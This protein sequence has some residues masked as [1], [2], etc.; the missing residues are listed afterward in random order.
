MGNMTIAGKEYT[1]QEVIA[2]AE[3]APGVLGAIAGFSLLNSVL[4]LF[5]V[6]MMF[7][8]GLGSTFVIDALLYTARQ[9]A[10]GGPMLVLT[11]IGLTI[12]AAIIGLFLLLWWLSRRGSRAA[13]ITAGVLYLLDGL[14]FLLLQ[15]WMG[16]GFHVFFLFLLFGG[17]NFVKHRAEAAA[18]LRAMPEVAE[19]PDAPVVPPPLQAPVTAEPDAVEDEVWARLESL[20][21]SLPAYSKQARDQMNENGE[22]NVYTVLAQLGFSHAGGGDE[23]DTGDMQVVHQH[24]MNCERA[25]YREQIKQYNALA[26]GSLL[27]MHASGRLDDAGYHEAGQLLA[28]FAARKLE[29]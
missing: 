8:I 19:G 17:Y 25:G 15:D 14:I 27:G 11:V 21:A 29:R 5:N 2:Q 12:N 10:E 1:P 16:V 20:W 26:L 18:H 6:D 9:E 24:L 28:E 23:W 7:V 22:E 3:R 13:Y 4:L